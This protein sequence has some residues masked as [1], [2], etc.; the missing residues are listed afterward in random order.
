M[1]G[2]LA[3]IGGERQCAFAATTRRRCLT[4]VKKSYS[5]RQAAR[6]NRNCARRPG[7]RGPARGEHAVH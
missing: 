5:G 6:A 2:P 4:N 7:V 1:N 3:Y